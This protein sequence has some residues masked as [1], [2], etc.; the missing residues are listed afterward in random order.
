MNRNDTRRAVRAL[1]REGL[2]KFA[3]GLWTEGGEMAG[4]GYAITDTGLWLVE[5]PTP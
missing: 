5:E 2:A 1:A 3:S 4:S